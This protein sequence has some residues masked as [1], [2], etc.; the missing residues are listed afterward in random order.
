[1]MINLINLDWFDCEIKMLDVE[2]CYFPMFVSS[3][4]LEKEKDHIE[5]FAPEGNF[6]G[7]M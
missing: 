1:M 3:K 7:I 2:N 6:Y 5:G 4:A